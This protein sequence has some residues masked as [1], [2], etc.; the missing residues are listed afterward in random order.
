[1]SFNRSGSLLRGKIFRSIDCVPYRDSPYSR[2]RR[3]NRQDYLCNKCKRPRH[4]A[5]E[6]PNVTVCN[7]CG[8]P[9][10]FHLSQKKKGIT[11]HF[12]FVRSQTMKFVNDLFSSLRSF[13][14]PGHL[15]GQCPNE[16]VCN[17]C[18]KMGHLARDCLN[19]R[20]PAHDAR[21][22]NNCY[23]AGHFAADSTNEKACN[24]CHKTGHRARDC[25][26]EPVCN[27][28]NISGH[29]ARQCAKSK[30]GHLHY[31]CPSARMYDRSGV[32]R[33]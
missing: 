8:L 28:C 6:C 13:V 31:E 11:F 4:F 16:P 24:N 3:N 17:M 33:Y 30:L 32:R 12:I 2:D 14:E 18:G 22:C 9:R 7:N 21:L 27:I 5:R 25:H 26:N 20:L 10:T 15:A 19:H 1:M 23:K 29:V